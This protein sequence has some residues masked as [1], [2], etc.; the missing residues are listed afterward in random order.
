MMNMASA[1]STSAMAFPAGS[2]AEMQIKASRY[3][4][5]LRRCGSIARCDVRGLTRR[6]P[7]VP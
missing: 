1:H 7:M 2:N 3:K 5:F 4:P 6:F